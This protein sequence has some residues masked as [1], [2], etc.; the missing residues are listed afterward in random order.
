MKRVDLRK[1][2]FSNLSFLLFKDILVQLRAVESDVLP[3]AQNVPPQ[4]FQM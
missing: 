2:C 1:D 4:L 3:D